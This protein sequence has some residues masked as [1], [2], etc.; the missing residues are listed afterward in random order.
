[1]RQLAREIRGS[2]PKAAGSDP[3]AGS[4]PERAGSDPK[5]AADRGPG[6]G[7]RAELIFVRRGDATVLAHAH[8]QAP[9]KIVRPFPLAGGRLVVPLITI[10]PGL[11]AGDACTIDVHVDEGARAIVTNTAATRLLG[12]REGTHAD[13]RVY[14]TAMS[15]AS[16][17]YYPGLTIPFPDSAFTQSIDV[18][19]AADARVGLL[20]TWACGRAARDEYLRF[21]RL[22]SRTMVHV[23]GALAYA[24][25]V[26]LDPRDARVDIA[27]VLDRRRYLVSGF[28]RG[29][30]LQPADAAPL[31]GELTARALAAFGRTNPRQVFLRALGDDERTLDAIVEEALARVARAW[32]VT[33]VRLARFRC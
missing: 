11:C 12:M 18:A 26:H 29:P 1:M 13:Q 5:C 2:D 22:R 21:R 6:S 20:E 10:G 16:L 19:A 7:G 9:L 31:P 3:S 30:D 28:W 25:A 32:R 4:D 27:G 15:G 23:D 8:A 33:P 17:E 14:L 24:D